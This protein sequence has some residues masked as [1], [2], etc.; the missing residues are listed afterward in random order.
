MRQ[1]KIIRFKNKYL[2]QGFEIGG[3]WSKNQGIA[4][5]EEY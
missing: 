3:H 2:S 1:V 4:L 5:D